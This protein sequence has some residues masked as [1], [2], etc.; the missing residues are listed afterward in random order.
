[1]LSA[2]EHGYVENII[3]GK[4]TY[5]IYEAIF[6][7]VERAAGYTLKRVGDPKYAQDKNGDIVYQG[8]YS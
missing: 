7:H 3:K 6:N 5:A 2:L 8:Q 1:M 4:P